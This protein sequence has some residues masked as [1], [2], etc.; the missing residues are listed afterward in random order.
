MKER[1]EHGAD[2]AEVKS[3]KKIYKMLRCGTS[4]M[5]CPTSPLLLHYNVVLFTLS[6]VLLSIF[7]FSSLSLS[8]TFGRNQKLTLRFK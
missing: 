8:G 5:F 1:E 7:V 6:T 2:Y 3:V 4:S